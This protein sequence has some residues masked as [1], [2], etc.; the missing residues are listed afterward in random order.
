MHRLSLS[1]RLG[2]AAALLQ[3]V[4]CTQVVHG[5]SIILYPADGKSKAAFAE[6]DH[7]CR[8]YASQILATPP[9]PQSLHKQQFRYDMAYEQCMAASG[10]PL[11]PNAFWS[12]PQKKKHYLLDIPNTANPYN[13]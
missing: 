10:N 11:P 13:P 7:T 3:L 1:L 12:D 6:E 5:P 8:V 9:L 4:G 2:L